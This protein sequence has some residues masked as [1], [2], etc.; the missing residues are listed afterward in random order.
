MY[1]Q[2]TIVPFSVTMTLTLLAPNAIPTYLLS[3]A[4]YI[5][6]IMSILTEVIYRRPFFSI[7]SYSDLDPTDPKCNPNPPL[8]IMYLYW[9]F[10]RN[11]SI[12][13]KVI[14]QK[15]PVWNSFSIISNSDLDPTDPKC[16]PNVHRLL[17]YLYTKF[18]SNMSILT[19]VISQ[20]PCF[21]F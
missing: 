2:E 6:G 19:E 1:W 9:K 18:H 15:H 21:Y 5:Q 14:Y 16:S 11:K 13:T 17:S 4:T 8:F 20:K 3:E 7:F 12:L 10:H